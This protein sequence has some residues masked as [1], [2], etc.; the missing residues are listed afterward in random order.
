MRCADSIVTTRSASSSSVAGEPAAP[1]VGGVQLRR[2]HRHHVGV[3]RLAV[4]RVRAGA[5]ELHVRESLGPGHR[6]G[7]RRAADVGGADE[8]DLHRRS[9][10]RRSRKPAS[11]RPTRTSSSASSMVRPVVSTRTSASCGSSYGEEM[12]VNSGI[13]PGPRLGVEALAVAALALLERRGDVDQE[14]RAAGVGDHL[15]HLLAGLV[16]RRDR[17]ADRDAAVPG[18]LRGHPADPADVGLAVLLGEGQSGRQVPAYDVAVEAGHGALALLEQQVVEGPGQRGL[19]AAGQAGE[20]EDQSLPV[21]RRPVV[22][23]DVGCTSAGRSPSPHRR[24]WTGSPAAK[25]ATTRTPNAWSASG[26]HAEGPV[27][28]PHCVRQQRRGGPAGAHQPDR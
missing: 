28:R 16:E 6:L 23:D 7:G 14:E 8:Q 21:R 18:D 1:E 25:A 22:V 19:A 15:P 11:R 17:A 5:A 2:Q 9:T 13:S 20:E 10:L 26:R 4:P 3:D 24:P 12:P 27:R